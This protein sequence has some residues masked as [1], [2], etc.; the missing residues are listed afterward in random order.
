[1]K[2]EGK[3]FVLE[4]VTISPKGSLKP[5]YLY[6]KKDR[7]NVNKTKS[8][9]TAAYISYNEYLSAIYFADTRQITLPKK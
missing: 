7:N 8:N 5:Q 9:L 4:P 1:M 2:Y 3:P 6:R